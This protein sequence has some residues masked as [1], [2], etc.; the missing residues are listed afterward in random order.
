MRRLGVRGVWLGLQSWMI[1]SVHV[2]VEFQGFGSGLGLHNQ[3]TLRGMASSKACVMLKT[4]V[5]CD[6]ETDTGTNTHTGK[7][8]AS[9]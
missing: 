5:D 7:G 3:I 6:A 9:D 8:Y 1:Q 2:K 4:C